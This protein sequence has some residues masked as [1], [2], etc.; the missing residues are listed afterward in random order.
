MGSSCNR[1]T[2]S[3][4]HSNGEIKTSIKNLNRQNQEILPIFL[5][6]K[7]PID[8]QKEELK[9]RNIGLLNQG[10]KFSKVYKVI[11]FILIKSSYLHKLKCNCTAQDL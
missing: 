7:F 3:G 5:H 11:E 8:T 2:N 9:E 10:P 1:K 6:Y 4:K